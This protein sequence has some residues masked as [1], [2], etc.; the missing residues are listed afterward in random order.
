MLS[1]EARRTPQQG[2]DEYLTADLTPEHTPK[3]TKAQGTMNYVPEINTCQLSSF[4]ELRCCCHHPIKSLTAVSLSEYVDT[5]S[6][7]TGYLR[8]CEL[9]T[10]HS[11][12][13]FHPRRFPFPEI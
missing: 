3:Y 4:T 11:R 6:P 12:A 9:D 13:Q 8:P 1:V 5:H 10:V 2:V 7:P